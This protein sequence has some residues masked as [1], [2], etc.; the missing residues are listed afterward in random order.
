MHNQGL[1]N[2]EIAN[3][4]GCKE[5]TITNHLNKMGVYTYRKNL[6]PQ[7]L[8]LHKQGYYD[9]EIAEILGCTRENVTHFLNKQGIKNRRSKINDINL[10]NRI[11]KSL[12]GRYVGVDNPNYKGYNE[13]K[14]IARGIFKTFSKRLLRQ[15][16]YTCQH[17]GCKG[18]NLEVHH[19]KPFYIIFDEFMKTTYSYNKQNLYHELMNYKDFI[20]ENN[21]VVLCQ[22]CHKQVHY[23][24]NHE[25]SPY[26]WESATTIE[27][28][29]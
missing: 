1:L 20:D 7:M 6:Q 23:S 18:G 15:Y 9:K 13:E 29:D 28:D 24:D 26:R 5:C 21:M 14:T 3:I 16:N 4:A 11:S 8:E 2:K 10:R 22:N 25:L 17:C 12:I 27:K 19:I